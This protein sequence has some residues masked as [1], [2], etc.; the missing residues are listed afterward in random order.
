MT[1]LPVMVCPTCR[2]TMPARSVFTLFGAGDGFLRVEGA[3]LTCQVFWGDVVDIAVIT[4]PG[5]SIAPPQG[6]LYRRARAG[7]TFQD[8]QGQFERVAL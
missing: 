8:A 4:F 6:R 7:S 3:P 2:D 5:R 1:I